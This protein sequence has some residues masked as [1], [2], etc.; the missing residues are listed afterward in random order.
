M[1]SAFN[2]VSNGSS[3]GPFSN[4]DEAE[5]REAIEAGKEK[6]IELDIEESRPK[7][8]RI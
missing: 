6:F 2:P 7:T 1:V 8:S 5:I 4:K 3:T